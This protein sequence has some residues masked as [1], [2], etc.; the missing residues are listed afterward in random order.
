MSTTKSQINLDQIRIAS[1]CNVGWDQMQGDERIR[2]CSQCHLN[3]Y[4]IAEMSKVEA[5]AL[6]AR[7]LDG[8]R[9]CVRLM[10]RHDGTILTKDCPVG[11]RRIQMLKLKIHSFRLAV[12]ALILGIVGYSRLS[13]YEEKIP[14]KNTH[15]F[16]GNLGEALT[17]DIVIEPQERLG[18]VALPKAE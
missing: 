11:H 10:R 7:Q 13:I 15:T 18:K 14:T 5:E 12:I 16:Q 3:V 4:N 2:N 6:I 9:V 8:K 1:P 17:G